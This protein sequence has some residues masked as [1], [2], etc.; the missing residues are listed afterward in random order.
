MVGPTRTTRRWL[1]P[2]V[3]AALLVAGCGAQSAG[4]SSRVAVPT[5]G[6]GSFLSGLSF[7]SANE[8]WAVGAYSPRLGGYGETASEVLRWDGDSWRLVRTPD[9]AGGGLNGASAVNSSS[10]YAVGY[11]PGPSGHGT[12]GLVLHWD[13]SRWRVAGVVSDRDGGDVDLLGVSTNA[14]SGTADGQAWVVGAV[15]TVRS[16]MPVARYW[17]GARWVD[18]RPVIPGT[19]AS[20][21]SVAQVGPADVWAVGSFFGGGRDQALIEHWNGLHWTRTHAAGLPRAKHA[22]L[23][24][25]AA[26]GSDDAWAVGYYAA[27]DGQGESTLVLHWN[28]HSWARVAAPNPGRFGGRLSSVS[29]ASGSDAWAVGVYYE[30][31]ATTLVERWDGHSW[32]RVEVANPGD[33]G[34]ELRAVAVLPDGSVVAAGDVRERGNL[35]LSARQ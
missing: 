21:S 20:L 10:V 27:G 2:A 23:E 31:G 24:G 12:E 5:P 9:S 16:A 25:V 34:S 13:G 11:R 7:A 14:D 15:T 33:V 18:T 3:A 19:A 32:R 17:D 8:A 1:A 29:A 6:H 26:V 30:H 28:G 22:R 35:L 4:N